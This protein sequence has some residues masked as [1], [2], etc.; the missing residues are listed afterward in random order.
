MVVSRAERTGVVVSANPDSVSTKPVAD[1]GNSPPTTGPEAVDAVEESRPNHGVV[2]G[3]GDATADA[4]AAARRARTV[5]RGADVA[6]EFAGREVPGLD[7][8]IAGTQLVEDACVLRSPGASNAEKVA[9]GAN[10]VAEIVQVMVPG[11]GS[12]AAATAIWRDA[13]HH[14]RT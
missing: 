5:L 9:A 7:L 1:S 11:T 13:E 2:L 4:G 14:S 12:I 3:T 6:A 8:A 10:A